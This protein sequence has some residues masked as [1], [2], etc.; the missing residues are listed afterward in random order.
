MRP[1]IPSLVEEIWA[2]IVRVIPS[3]A[4]IFSGPNAELARVGLE[5]NLATF[6]E[7]VATPG[8]DTS[9]RDEMCR[10]FGR[11][12]AESGR[13]LDSLQE[14]YRVGARLALRRARKV[15]RRFNLSPAV[16]LTFAD[17]LFAY[18]GELS[19][20]SREGYLS[21]LAE[22]RQ[23]D[24]QRRV[25]LLR[26][27]LGASA[28]P[29]V[30]VAELGEQLG[31]PIPP[32]VT[33]VVV[34][35]EPSAGGDGS[36]GAGGNGPRPALDPD[37]LTELDGSEPRLLLPGPMTD[38]RR[39]AL[40]AALPGRPLAVGLTV[41]AAEAPDSLRWARQALALAA[42]GAIAPDRDGVVHCEQHLVT[43]WLHS[44][45]TLVD[46][47]ARRQ[48]EPLAG[49]TPLQRERLIET[50]HSWLTTRGT[51]ARIAEEL[52]VHP[53]TV[54]YRMRLLEQAFG[55]RLDDPDQQF[56]TEIV[57]RRLHRPSDPE[58]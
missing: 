7:Q 18:T 45:P 57:L 20:L 40:L 53:Q 35:P 50:L 25:R 48:L 51:A 37:I 10:A 26:L 55:D 9:L 4:Q 1:E 32:E 21:A 5:Q 11:L 41:P 27:L 34:G 58:A 30:P 56:A 12:E 43:L 6:V 16:I 31:W 49:L 2:E 44:A 52:S 29:S 54:R 22:R 39:T 47:L 24:D 42:S 17:A 13:S 14:T 3:Y 33:P 28:N 8:A 36:R 46:Q 38:E 15:G 19:A 23:H